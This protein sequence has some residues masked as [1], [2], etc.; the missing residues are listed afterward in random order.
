MNIAV[1]TVARAGYELAARVLSDLR[2]QGPGREAIVVNCCG[3]SVTQALAASF[4]TVNIV[5]VSAGLTG[6]QARYAG[7]KNS[8]AEVVAVVHERYRIPPGWCAAIESAQRQDVDV[9]GGGI[10]PG[11]GFGNMEWAMYLTEYSQVAPPLP[12]GP[13]DLQASKMLPG[14]NVSYKRRVF[15]MA[16][17]DQAL[18]ELDF[19]EALH[20]AGARFSRCSGMDVQ[21]ASPLTFGEYLEERRRFSRAYGARRFRTASVPA[22]ALA[23]AS[24]LAL[25]PL[26]LTRYA[27]QSWAKADLRAQFW[28]A[29]PW[30]AY[31][32]WIQTR[33]EIAGIMNGTDLPPHP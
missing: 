19:H 13:L 22:R 27:R 4:P 1:V 8:T 26:L 17:M 24:R 30:M 23:A 5:E 9:A 15:E 12:E 33:E 10:A 11:P 29:L 16:P 2:D 28:P 25:P 6:A 32:A 14:G 18:S 21:F 3:P 7:I 31:F 20:R